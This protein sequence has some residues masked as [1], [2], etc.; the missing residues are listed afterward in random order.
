[1]IDKVEERSVPCRLQIDVTRST[2]EG[3]NW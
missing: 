3:R 1:V 2:Q